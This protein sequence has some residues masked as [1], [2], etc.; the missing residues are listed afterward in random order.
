MLVIP[1][2]IILAILLSFIMFG[3]FI[4]IAGIIGGASAALLV[5]NKTFKRLLFIGFCIVSFAGFLCV[6][7][8]VMLYVNFSA[9]PITAI[10]VLACVF[11]VVLAILGIK[12]TNGIQ[13]KIGKSVII[14]LF[15][16]AL[17]IALSLG[18]IISA[19]SGYLF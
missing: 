10:M 1:A 3:I 5:K 7:P 14:I 4:A 6:I 17:A 18:I 2:L 9:A 8:F 19:I 12:F 16:L 13:N 11:I 15:S